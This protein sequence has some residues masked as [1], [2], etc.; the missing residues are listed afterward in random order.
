MSRERSAAPVAAAVLLAALALGA[1]AADAQAPASKPCE[2]EQ[3]RQFDFWVGDWQVTQADGTVAGT[4]R[5]EKILDGCVLKESWVGAGGGVRGESF[6]VYA[7]GRWHQTWVDTAGRLLVLDG[8]LHDG[9][10]VLA[11]TTPGKDGGAVQHEIAWTPLEDGR[12]KQ[13]W[14]VSRDGG[15]SWNDVFVGF[16]ARK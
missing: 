8:G 6:N 14:R 5:I 15:E 11:G 12:V 1:S 7:G 2:T 4:N 16:Y 3:H 13:H 10:M 9:K